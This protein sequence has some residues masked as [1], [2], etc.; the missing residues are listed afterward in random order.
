MNGNRHAVLGGRNSTLQEKNG[1]RYKRYKKTI[2]LNKSALKTMGMYTVVKARNKI[3]TRS[4][5]S[6]SDG[7]N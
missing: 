3:D 4:T 5:K 1:F 2:K 6:K 7:A